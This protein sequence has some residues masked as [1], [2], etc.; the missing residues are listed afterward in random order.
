MKILQILNSPHWSASSAYCI[1]VS[2]EL[3]KLGHDV[4]IM[5]ILGRALNHIKELGIPYNDQLKMGQSNLLGYVQDIKLLKKIYKYFKPDIISAHVN[6]NA[7]LPGF[8]A[9]I[10]SPDSVVVRVRTDIAAP[11]KNIFN[12]WVHHKWTDHIICGSQQHK[13]I[14]IKNLFLSP[15]KL[16]IIYGSVDAEKFNPN[17]YD[18]NIRKSLNINED[19]F[20]VCLLGRLSPIKGHEYALKAI[21]LLKDYAPKIKILCI[22]YEA[23]RSFDW[24]KTEAKKLDILDRLICIDYCNNLPAYLNLID[25][26][27]ITSLGSEA[28]SRAALEYMACGKAVIATN[29]GVLPEIIKNNENGFLIEKGNSEVLAEALK[30][31]MLDRK[32]CAEMG[33]ASRKIVEEKYTLEQFGKKME[34]I[35]LNLLEN[36]L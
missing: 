30:K 25:V 24:L 10:S 20:A 26:G 23:Q 32:L 18:A 36:K 19:D 17:A 11:N 1:N 7:W 16:S 31:L 13:D 2:Y 4:L 15:Q 14:C 12:L 22:G 6:K 21:S 8:V 33:K 9:K 29:V 35:Y 28:N 34:A 27:I 3:I 5:T